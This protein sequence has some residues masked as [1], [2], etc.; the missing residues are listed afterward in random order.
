V[1]FSHSTLP[2]VNTTFR[3]GDAHGTPHLQ[4]VITMPCTSEAVDRRSFLTC[5]R[6][7]SEREKSSRQHAS[8]A[9]IVSPHCSRVSTFDDRSH[10]SSAEFFLLTLRAILLL[11]ADAAVTHQ[12]SLSSQS[13]TSHTACSIRL[14]ISLCAWSHNNSSAVAEMGDRLATIDTGRGLYLPTKWHLDTSV[15]LAAIHQRYRQTGQ[16]GQ[17]KG[18]IA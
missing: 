4:E 16:T 8:S 7:R 10:L 11:A 14:D 6:D 1:A 17:D 2:N 5:V 12:L 13:D 9:P 15:R 18:P 3:P